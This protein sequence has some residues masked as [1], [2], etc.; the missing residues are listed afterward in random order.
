MWGNDT[1]EES[2]QAIKRTKKVH[3]VIVHIKKQF[4]KNF[5]TGKSLQLMNQQMGSREK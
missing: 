2:N 4:Q 3:G 5:V 1:T